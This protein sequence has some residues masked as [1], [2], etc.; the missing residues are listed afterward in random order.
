MTYIIVKA[1]KSINSVVGV[2]GIFELTYFK[3]AVYQYMDGYNENGLKI[4]NAH[5]YTPIANLEILCRELMK[6]NYMGV[7]HPHPN[8]FRINMLKA[9]PLRYLRH[10]RMKVG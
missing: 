2:L 5:V 1:L 10:L 8:V 3:R 6:I 9:K 7:L 4:L